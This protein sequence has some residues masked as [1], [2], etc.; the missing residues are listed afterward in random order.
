MTLARKP[1]CFVAMAFDHDDTDSLYEKSIKPVLKSLGV[2]P[3]IINR[4]EDNRDINQQIIK[5]LNACDFC[6][7]DLTYTRP[8]VYFEAGYAQRA[9]EVVYTVRNDHLHKNQPDDR[10]VHFDLQMKPLIR[11]VGPDDEIL[12][13]LLKNE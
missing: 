8:S 5:Q 9:V 12:N 10:R 7:A 3:V 4:R 6:I 2:I 11:W 1:R 13:W